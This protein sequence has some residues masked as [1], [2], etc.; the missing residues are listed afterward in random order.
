MAISYW[1]RFFGTFFFGF[2]VLVWVDS[3]YGP[4]Y[5][6]LINILGILAWLS[7]VGV[8]AAF[9]ASPREFIQKLHRTSR[10]EAI[11]GIV[12]VISGIIATRIGYQ[13]WTG[14]VLTP[15]GLIVEWLLD[16]IAPGARPGY[17]GDGSLEGFTGFV[18]MMVALAILMF[19]AVIP[20]VIAWIV[21]VWLVYKF[22]KSDSFWEWLSEQ[23]ISELISGALMSIIDFITGGS[24][25][26]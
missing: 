20:V 13:A 25:K 3:T 17:S 16:I 15:I 2:Y 1:V 21:G 11:L 26:K 9:F 24:D 19:F 14:S 12:I 22:R 8:I 7:I 5:P 4:I 6:S 18:R 23:A 10:E